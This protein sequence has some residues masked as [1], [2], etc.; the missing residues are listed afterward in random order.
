MPCPTN[1]E[2]ESL[3]VGTWN[4]SYI[5]YHFAEM[6]WHFCGFVTLS[7]K[8]TFIYNVFLNLNVVSRIIAFHRCSCP[9]SWN[10]CLCYTVKDSLAKWCPT[11]IWKAEF[12]N[13]ENG[14]LSERISTK[15]LEIWSGPFLLLIVKWERKEMD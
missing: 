11:T 15:A 12:V 10:L 1:T 13:E 9:N 14:H 8:Y 2:R 4:V 3:C 7:I 6:P 5:W